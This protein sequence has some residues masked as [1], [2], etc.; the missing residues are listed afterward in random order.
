MIEAGSCYEKHV[1][2]KCSQSPLSEIIL[3]CKWCD[4]IVRFPDETAYNIYRRSTSLEV[5][6]T[7]NL[8]T[9]VPGKSRHHPGKLEFTIKNLHPPRSDETFKKPKKR[10]L[11][12]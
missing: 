12:I 2:K 11:G 6:S 9:W 5:W 1:C 10:K 8:P 7:E 4:P 3:P